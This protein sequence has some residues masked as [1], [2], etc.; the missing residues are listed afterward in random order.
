MGLGLCRRP[1]R[2]GAKEL[3][4]RVH[5]AAAAARA[6]RPEGAIKATRRRRRPATGSAA[7]GGIA[8]SAGWT[9]PKDDAGPPPEHDREG[10]RDARVRTGRR[11][12]SAQVVD[13][14][15]AP[16]RRVRDQVAGRR[17]VVHAVGQP[18]QRQLAVHAEVGR[19]LAVRAVQQVPGVDV[20]RA[21]PMG[22]ATEARIALTIGKLCRKPGPSGIGRPSQTSVIPA[23][24]SSRVTPSTRRRYSATQPA[25]RSCRRSSPGRP[26]CSRGRRRRRTTAP[27]PAASRR[28]S[29]G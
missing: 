23:A 5:G 18:H 22:G 26:P 21:L 8:G 3:G 13:P 9:D 16:R 6:G 12:R 28:R 19:V 11:R 7:P 1:R 2:R 14:G 24:F 25:C 17:G 27:P 29:A 20:L 15:A 10:A 4:S